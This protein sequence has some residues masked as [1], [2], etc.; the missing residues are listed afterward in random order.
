MVPLRII[1]EAFF[2]RVSWDPSDRSITI[3]NCTSQSR[4]TVGS[5]KVEII[6]MGEVKTTTIDSP[7]EIRSGKTFIPLRA[8]SDILGASIAWE[9][10]TKTVT[11]TYSP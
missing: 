8:V 4:F 1:A 7:P 9:Q 10:K 3:T 11:I 6:G 2:A 5:K